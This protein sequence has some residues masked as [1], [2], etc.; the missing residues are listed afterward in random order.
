MEKSVFVMVEF[1]PNLEYCDAASNGIENT[2][3]KALP[4]V[5]RTFVSDHFGLMKNS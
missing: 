3:G 1:V 4:V 2:L 5:Q